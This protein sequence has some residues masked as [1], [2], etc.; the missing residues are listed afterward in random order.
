MLAMTKTN[1]EKVELI[2]EN[3]VTSIKQ[4]EAKLETVMDADQGMLKS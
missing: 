4:M 3:M 1:K 2:K